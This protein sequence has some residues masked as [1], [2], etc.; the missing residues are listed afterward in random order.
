LST[1]DYLQSTTP[2]TSSGDVIHLPYTP[3][4]TTAF[5]PQ[6]LGMS[7]SSSSAKPTTPGVIQSDLV[8]QTSAG[9][10]IQAGQ[11]AG[12][13]GVSASSNQTKS[14]PDQLETNR[15]NV[16]DDTQVTVNRK[17]KADALQEKIRQNMIKAART[18]PSGEGENPITPGVIQSGSVP[19]SSA[20]D[21]IQTGQIANAPVASDS[22]KKLKDKTANL[23]T[24][25]GSTKDDFFVPVNRQEKAVAVTKNTRK[26]I[27]EAKRDNPLGEGEI[28]TTPE[29]R[30]SDA[31]DPADPS[32]TRTIGTVTTL[33]ALPVR[34]LLANNLG[35]ARYIQRNVINP[36]AARREFLTKLREN[37]VNEGIWTPAN[38]WRK[39]NK[40]ANLPQ[41]LAAMFPYASKWNNARS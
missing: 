37:C 15:G 11:S 9:D 41:E 29:I 21:L 24:D 25:R 2:T 40:F 35:M 32:T 20:G 13:L 10:L 28:D 38:T 18:K 22:V 7:S 3:Q 1:S 8:P 33:R 19:Q 12:S 36:P 31:A 34:P 5:Q 14:K 30:P 27:I 6:T 4:A 39:R 17:E 16:K 26:L 23:K